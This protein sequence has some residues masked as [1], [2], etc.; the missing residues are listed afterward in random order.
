MRRSPKET[1]VLG[2]VSFRLDVKNRF[3]VI[4]QIQGGDTD[5]ELNPKDLS[6]RKWFYSGMPEYTLYDAVRQFALAIN[7]QA[8]GIPIPLRTPSIYE[9]VATYA[10]HVAG[11]RF[12]QDT[13]KRYTFKELLT[14][15]SVK[16]DPSP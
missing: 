2:V 12:A 10:K 4:E 5:Q 11:S 15:E 6:E 14:R 16:Y 8:I 1:K 3:V 9:K 13:L 7:F